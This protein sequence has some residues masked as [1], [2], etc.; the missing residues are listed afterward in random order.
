M[1]DRMYATVL[2]VGG[3]VFAGC[4]LLGEAV[5]AVGGSGR[6]VVPEVPDDAGERFAHL[7]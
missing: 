4:L 6:I 5:D 2:T 1:I 7:G 3:V